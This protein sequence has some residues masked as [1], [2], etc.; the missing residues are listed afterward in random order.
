MR[1]HVE[2][3]S[4]AKNAWTIVIEL[5]RDSEGKRKRLYRTVHC[6]RKS[7]AEKKMQAM[8][9]ELETG[10]SFEAAN[11]TVAGYLNEWLQNYGQPKLSQRTFTSYSQL[12]NRHVIPYIGHVVLVELKPMHLQKLYT[13]LTAPGARGDGKPGGLS[14]ASLLYIHRIL[15]KA[16]DSAVKWQLAVRNVT[17][18]VEL[19]SRPAW[20]ADEAD[21]GMTVLTEAQVSAM[22]RAAADTPH[23][24][25]VHVAVMTGMRRGEVYGLRWQDVDLPGRCI[26]VRQTIQYDVSRGVFFKEPKNRHSRRQVAITPEDADVLR[27]HRQRQLEKRI[28]LGEVYQ[29][30]GLV[31]CQD[32]GNPTHPDTITKW[33]PRFMANNGLPRLRFHD[34]RHTHVTL[35]IKAGVDIKT[36]SKRV[37]HASAT[38]TL[39]NYGHVL[40]DQQESAALKLAALIRASNRV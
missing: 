17:D 22:L 20:H 21:E 11:L 1:G 24:A 15:H 19:P 7:E 5:E 29:D 33:F 4:D 9:T 30:H 27:K 28:Q 32:D 39:N 10:L 35:L 36:V 34:L 3:R 13:R 12:I 18:A 26:F 16:L 38:M 2:K 25:A 8:I 6:S 14:H 37:G 31:F 23:Y 40:P